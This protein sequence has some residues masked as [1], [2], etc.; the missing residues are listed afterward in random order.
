MPREIHEEQAKGLGDSELVI[1]PSCGHL[2]SIEQ[3]DR[4]NAAL[5][6]WLARVGAP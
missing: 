4:V 3:P 5:R 1:V 2:S 6:R